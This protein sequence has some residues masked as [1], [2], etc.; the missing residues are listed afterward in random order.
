MNWHN[1]QDGCRFFNRQRLWTIFLQWAFKFE[2][3]STT[4]YKCAVLFQSWNY[5]ELNLIFWFLSM[6]KLRRITH[7]FNIKPFGFYSIC[8]WFGGVY[9]SIKN[10]KLNFIP[11]ILTHFI[12][13]CKL[14][15]I[16]MRY[17]IISNRSA[18]FVKRW[19]L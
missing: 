4:L 16:A 15:N 17:N 10:K 7:K 1:F 8:E 11:K 6:C 13:N 19:N 2:K 14:C 12:P 5:K 3:L 9:T 18:H